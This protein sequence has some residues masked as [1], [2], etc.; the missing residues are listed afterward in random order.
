MSIPSYW[1]G[2]DWHNG[3]NDHK[4]TRVATSQQTEFGSRQVSNANP[5][6][7][8]V[9]QTESQL[10]AALKEFNTA[11]LP[12]DSYQY[13]QIERYLKA[14]AAARTLRPPQGERTRMERARDAIG[15]LRKK[16]ALGT[17]ET[18]QMKTQLL[19]L[20]EDPSYVTKELR[21]LY[22]QHGIKIEKHKP[23]KSGKV[24]I[25][26]IRVIWNDLLW[27]DFELARER[28]ARDMQ[29][30]DKPAL[31]TGGKVWG[32]S[33]VDFTTSSDTGLTEGS[34]DHLPVLDREPARRLFSTAA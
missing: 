15:E 14:N 5:A 20:L 1:K 2:L 23:P 19:T 16:G 30:G 24:Q 3:W 28:I 8:I 26:G 32:R 34:N 31:T 18:S 11:T 10:V 6:L 33:G 29:T 9:T 25:T 4:P 7:E 27:L 21:P 13:R 12:E 22:A 17:A